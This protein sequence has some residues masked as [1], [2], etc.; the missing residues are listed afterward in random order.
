MSEWQEREDDQDPEPTKHA[1]AQRVTEDESQRV[2]TS[3]E[4]QP[5]D[6]SGT[7]AEAD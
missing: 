6:A 7:S 5:E 3:D 1:D 2:P 4:D